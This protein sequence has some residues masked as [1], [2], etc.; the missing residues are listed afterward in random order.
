MPTAT[1]N[2]SSTYYTSYESLVFVLVPME[3]ILIHPPTTKPV[4]P[5]AEHGFGCLICLGEPCNGFKSIRGPERLKA[6]NRGW[7]GL[8]KPF[9]IPLMSPHQK[10]REAF[11]EYGG[12]QTTISAMCLVP[13]RCEAY[14]ILSD[15]GNEKVQDSLPICFGHPKELSAA[16]ADPSTISG[17]PWH[18]LIRE[19]TNPEIESALKDP[20]MNSALQA[21]VS[22]TRKAVVMHIPSSLREVFRKE[23]IV[24]LAEVVGKRI[25]CRLNGSRIIK[26]FLGP[27]ERDNTEYKLETFVVVYKKPSS[28][29]VALEYPLTE[30]WIY[31]S[32][33]FI[34]I[35]LLP[36]HTPD[37]DRR[38]ATDVSA[39][40]DAQQKPCLPV[41]P[42]TTI[43]F[44]P[45]TMDLRR[46]RCEFKA[47][48]VSKD[49]Y[50][51]AIKEEIN[52]AVIIQ[53]ELGV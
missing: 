5:N 45:Q 22:S 2:Q 34:P 47:M 9:G 38:R 1:L 18:F 46:V 12:K 13:E 41:L 11:C 50:D 15:E 10:F 33:S 25:R 14:A 28:Q 37:S 23:D 40:L 32:K 26:I 51:K 7:D 24:L 4:D 21:D 31:H 48:K 53:E 20:Y 6:W 44:F 16:L 30:A 49:D 3:C 29:D 39:W 27:K 17:L 35:S 8:A 19:N 42:T 43:G 36:M 52:E